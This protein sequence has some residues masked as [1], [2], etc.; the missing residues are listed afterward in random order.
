MTTINTSLI[1]G[2]EK[3]FESISVLKSQVKRLFADRDD[4]SKR[5]LN[6]ENELKRVEMPLT[7]KVSNGKEVVIN[8]V[9]DI[10]GF[11]VSC[12][13]C[14][15]MNHTNK[16]EYTTAVSYPS[17]TPVRFFNCHFCSKQVVIKK[18]V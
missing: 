13:S 11:I 10:Y 15:E 3:E 6:L 8:S 1:D 14:K 18:E 7:P 17:R 12:P 9:A 5:I 2:L 16:D 4:L